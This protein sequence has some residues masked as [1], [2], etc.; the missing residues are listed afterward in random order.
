M[1]QKE[2]RN[3]FS[4]IPIL[5][6]IKPGKE[7]K[8]RMCERRPAQPGPKAAPQ[9]AVHNMRI[10]A[11]RILYRGLFFESRRPIINRAPAYLDPKGIL[12]KSKHL[13]IKGIYLFAEIITA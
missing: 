13:F 11:L 1:Q 2:F 10:I 9:E 6:G 4:G 3:N 12:M 7:P 8:H 5:I